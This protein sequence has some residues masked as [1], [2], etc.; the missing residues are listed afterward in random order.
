MVLLLLHLADPAAIS[1]GAFCV[2]ADTLVMLM[3]AAGPA[4]AGTLI[5]EGV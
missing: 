2:E 3:G 4:I 5:D 1:R